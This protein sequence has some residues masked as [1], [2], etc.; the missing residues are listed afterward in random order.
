MRAGF[1]PGDS[2]SKATNPPIVKALNPYDD[3]LIAE[4]F[5]KQI[6]LVGILHETGN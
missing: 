3:E 1:N 6:A 4:Y 5:L 2:Y